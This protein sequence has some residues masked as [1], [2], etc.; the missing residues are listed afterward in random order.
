MIADR[1]YKLQN[2]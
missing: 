1:Q 2:E